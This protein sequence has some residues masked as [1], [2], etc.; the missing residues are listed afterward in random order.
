MVTGTELYD[1]GVR[2]VLAFND[3][4]FFSLLQR[5]RPARVRRLRWEELDRTAEIV[6]GGNFKMDL[7]GH[8]KTDI[9]LQDGI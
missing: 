8:G 6:S 1:A 3:A 5:G 7:Y 9:M 2:H 4:F